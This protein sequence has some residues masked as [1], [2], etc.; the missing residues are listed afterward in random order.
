VDEK[1]PAVIALKAAATTP[2]AEL[3]TVE[4]RVV[5][6]NNKP[7]ANIP[8][9]VTDAVT[10]QSQK[11]TTDAQGKFKT[12]IPAGNAYTVAITD[13]KYEPYVAEVKVDDKLPAVI[14]L[15][16]A[17]TTPP[18]AELKTVEG[19]V[20]DANNKPLANIPVIVTDAVT[21]QSQKVTTD[22]QGKFKTTIPAG[23]AYTVA[24]TD[25]KYEPYVAEVKVDEKL[26][27][28]I[29][30]KA[31]TTTVEGRVVD[32]N[33]KPLANIP[34]IVT[35]VVTKQSQ[36]VTTDAQGKF[37][38]TIPAGNAYTVAITDAKYEPFVAEVAA[39]KQLASTVTLK[40]KE[41]KLAT[42]SQ[43]PKQ[44]VL[45]I[46]FNLDRASLSDEEIRK[47][48][49]IISSLKS[50]EQI[51]LVGYTDEV[52]GEGYNSRLANRRM[53]ALITFLKINGVTQKIST[54]YKSVPAN[55]KNSH[56]ISTRKENN[57]VEVWTK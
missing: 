20:V 32:A 47:I 10:K 48:Q 18:V 45:T 22:A 25:A 50:S 23:N 1:S 26:P 13:A 33:N 17:A 43:K 54:S 24:I 12:T 53:D 35:D 46:Y 14:S 30:L 41:T 51:E 42:S 31:A 15:K 57:R 39:G 40:P 19:R 2:V 4:G 36:K 3:K 55:V 49:N 34:V 28:V 27:A 11:V 37:K 38:T 21:K 52:G 7:L 9:I 6:A 29:A 5:D 56:V 16:A 8:V 44:L